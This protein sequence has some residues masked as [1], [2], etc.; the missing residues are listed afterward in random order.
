MHAGRQHPTRP[1]PTPPVEHHV[2]LTRSFL[3]LPLPLPFLA[4]HASFSPPPPRAVP[5]ERDAW[6]LPIESE[7]ISERGKQ[8]AAE[9]MARQML[10][11]IRTRGC[12]EEFLPNAD[13]LPLGKV[14][15]VVGVGE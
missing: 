5:K 3:P 12:K 4:S 14:G 11:R 2:A 6:Q 8:S 1:S 9:E 15:G 7:A 10:V 13:L